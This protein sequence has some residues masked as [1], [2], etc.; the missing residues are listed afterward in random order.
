MDVN[1]GKQFLVSIIIVTYNC[2]G[3]IYD[4]IRSIHAYADIPLG[5]I[6]IIVVDNCSED[7]EG[8]FLRLRE[9]FGESLVLL[10]NTRNGGYGQ[11]NNIGIRQASAPIVLIMNPD[12]RLME[13][14]MKP[15]LQAFEADERLSIYGMKMMQTP[16]KPSNNSFACTYMMNGY[17]FTLL[18]SVA[19]KLDWFMP[20]CMHISG[21]CFFLRKEPFE[22]IGLFDE[23][24]FLYGEED[25]IHYR[26][27]KMF[28]AH[29]VYNK[30]LHYLH[31]TQGREPSL[32]YEKTKV[33]VAV[34]QAERKG[35]PIERMLRNRL[36]NTELLLLRE[37]LRGRR[38][39]PH[40]QVLRQLRDYLQSQLSKTRECSR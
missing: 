1:K 23:T 40:A 3:D 32:K 9:C 21:A 20:R 26:L 36:Q 19:N 5:E 22:R 35:Y 31:L 34:A 29:F 2:E 10:R 12:V 18:S 8:M 17:L 14:V 33:D 13:P 6:E 38:T 28:G 11:G 24:V 27:R 37:T 16:T 15:A 30:H 7:G 25:D 39:Q 4:C